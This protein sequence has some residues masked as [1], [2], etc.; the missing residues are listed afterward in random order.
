MFREYSWSYE[1]THVR[2]RNPVASKQSQSGE[3]KLFGPIKARDDYLEVGSLCVF[4][5]IHVVHHFTDMEVHCS[6]G[7]IGNH[8]FLDLQEPRYGQQGTDTSK[9]PVGS[10]VPP[11]VS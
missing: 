9:S 2:Q 1:H 10:R 8:E 7:R 3:T 5:V 11:C 6:N 4:Q